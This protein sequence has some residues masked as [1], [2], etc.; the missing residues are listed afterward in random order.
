MKILS[1]DT[2]TSIHTNGQKST[3]YSY[4]IKSSL[5][6]GSYH[7]LAS[8]VD[9]SGTIYA[10]LL[11][12]DL[13]WSNATVLT[14]QAIDVYCPSATVYLSYDSNYLVVSYPLNQDSFWVLVWDITNGTAAW[15][16]G[17]IADAGKIAG[18][19]IFTDDLNNY[20][21]AGF[22]V[23]NDKLLF[24]QIG[25]GNSVSIS[26]LNADAANGAVQGYWNG[27]AYI[28]LKR[29]TTYY[30]RSYT[31]ATDTF[32]T[33]SEPSI[34]P[35]SALDATDFEYSFS[36]YI[37]ATNI[38]YVWYQSFYIYTGSQWIPSATAIIGFHYPIWKGYDANYNRTISYFFD[39]TYFYRFNS[40]TRSFVSI[41]HNYDF[42]EAILI[43]PGWSNF[44]L[45]QTEVGDPA[46][47]TWTTYDLTTVSFDI[48]EKCQI[49]TKAYT[50]PD[51]IILADT[52]PIDNEYLILYDDND[53]QIYEGFV[54]SY[55]SRQQGVYTYIMRSP[56]EQDF[57]K[58]ITVSYTAQTSHAILKDIIDNYCD[59]LWYD[60]GISTTPATTYTKT[61]ENKTI[62]E[63]IKWL[64]QQENY[65]TSIRPTLEVY[66]D[67]YTDSGESFTEGTDFPVQT[68]TYVKKPLKLS[69]VKLNGGMVNGVRLTAISYGEANYGYYE[70][71]L[72]HITSQTELQALADAIV[73]NKNVVLIKLNLDFATRGM[74]N[75]GTY[76]AITSDTYSISGD[77]YYI[78]GTY[79]DAVSDI[80]EIVCTSALYIPSTKTS[81]I[82]GSEAAIQNELYDLKHQVD[83]LYQVADQVTN[84]LQI[85]KEPT[86]FEN[87]TGSAF[88]LTDAAPRLL[89]VTVV[90]GSYNIYFSGIK[91]TIS[92]TKSITWADTEGIHAVY[93][94]TDDT[95]QEIVNPTV[96]QYLT[97][98]TTKC[99]V[100]VFYWD[101]TN[102]V[103]MVPTEERHGLTMDGYTHYYLHYTRKL[104]YISG[105]TLGN[106][107]I[108]DGSLDT[109]AQFSIA[110]GSV[111]DEDIELTSSA[112]NVGTGGSILYVSGANA[113]WRKTTQAGFW[114]KKS[115]SATD[116]LYYNQYTGGAWQLTEVGEGNYVLCHLYLISGKLEQVFAIMGRA[117]YTTLS[118]AQAGAKTEI[119]AIQISTLP[120]AEMIP[121]ATLIFQT[122]KDYANSIH[123]RIVQ[124]TVGGD[125]YISWITNP[126]TQGAAFVSQVT[127]TITDGVTTTAPSEN[128]V[129]DALA[130]KLPIADL[131]TTPTNGATTKAP[132]SDWA[133]KIESEAVTLAGVKTFSSDPIVPAEAYGAGWNGSNEPP[134]K[135]DTYNQMETRTKKSADADQNMNGYAVI[136]M[137]KSNFLKGSNLTISNGAITVTNNYHQVD[138][139][140]AAASDDLT[141][142]SG[143]VQGMIV[144]LRPVNSGRDIV[145]KHGTGN[146]ICGS[147][148]N[149]LSVNYNIV[150]LCVDGSNWHMLAYNAL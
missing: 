22:D 48:F 39:T 23:I 16:E 116:R 38:I 24:Y 101:A 65:Q 5:T 138:T 26:Y 34:T 66:R 127:Q 143:G 100:C 148:R 80:C 58:Q 97:M 131:E 6:L 105:F 146:I 124:V 93:F 50:P 28:Y 2:N 123:A 14:S 141:T 132:N 134:T 63:I 108:G 85:M 75:Y 137:G 136:D 69:I 78:L 121:F 112:I 61:F 106:F 36:V 21:M 77:N 126:L 95:L 86:G 59:F 81:V 73:T 103:S 114:V 52:A 83:D 25:N 135:N 88:T 60:S 109:H 125:N 1:F 31:V 29:A 104:Q 113:E 44:I 89:E 4:G 27:T 42:T 129:Y 46:T 9:V 122:D 87:R 79:Y 10:R 68:F 115:G 119:S 12:F 147:D 55:E 91:H 18:S 3:D 40:N 17:S 149:L 30:L 64:D 74:L 72:S 140:G 47:Y 19:D 84:A 94:D 35:T 128:A 7:Y 37:S 145:V 32:A 70:D 150:L 107:V 51:C 139:E 54:E 98:M 142:I 102:N 76:L 53:N 56:V 117:E 33:I 118:T 92:A 82:T 62:V 11:R 15:D 144:V 99:L 110:V 67:T 13:D 130:L 90:S 41:V 120:A 20:I 8:S 45:V 49:T 43:R 133:Y 111:S 57:S 71:T 96:A